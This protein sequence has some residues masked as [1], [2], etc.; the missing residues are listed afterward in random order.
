MVR[1]SS[2]KFSFSSQGASPRGKKLYLNVLW[3]P[4]LGAFA[5]L[6]ASSAKEKIAH[7]A[8]PNVKRPNWTTLDSLY[9]AWW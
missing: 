6:R 5:N 9:K 2:R 4:T 8:T 7:V 3:R 1:F